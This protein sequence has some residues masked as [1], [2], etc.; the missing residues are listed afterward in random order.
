MFNHSM[1]Y[2][3]VV[4]LGAAVSVEDDEKLVGLKAISDHIIPGRWSEARLPNPTELNATSV[5]K[6]E[7]SEAS[8]KVRN[9]PPIDDADD[10]MLPYWA[11]V[12]PLALR[13]AQPIAEERVT[14]AI[15]LPECIGRLVDNMNRSS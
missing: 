11:G 2:R 15:G 7:I 4:I 6:L 8:A 12:I 1:N 10:L 5:L 14:K 13:A 9:G 3:S